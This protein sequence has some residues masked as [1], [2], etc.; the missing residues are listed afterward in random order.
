MD[1]LSAIVGGILAQAL[2]TQLQSQ[3]A[4]GYE[5]DVWKAQQQAAEQERK[6]QLGYQQQ[7]QAQ[8]A[9]TLQRAAPTQAKIDMARG[10]REGEL[11]AAFAKSEGFADPTG[12]SPTVE[13]AMLTRT[14]TQGA[15]DA[16]TDARNFAALVAPQDVMFGGNL[17]LQQG[18]GELGNIGQM[19]AGSSRLLPFN[20]QAAQAGVR[21]PNNGFASLLQGGGQ[22]A[23]LGGFSARP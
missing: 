19:S 15:R 7:A 16:R 20:I 6:K 17:A 11:T 3:N 1:P 5:Q 14:A 12:S 8:Q 22:L 2:G 23:T 18:A 10:E 13:D 21:R 9:Q 4:A